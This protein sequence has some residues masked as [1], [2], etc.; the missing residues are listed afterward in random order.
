MF[1][2]KS[3]ISKTPRTTSSNPKHQPERKPEHQPI[4]VDFTRAGLKQFL[5]LNNRLGS[6]FIRGPILFHELKCYL[7]AYEVYSA[8]SA[9]EMMGAIDDVATATAHV[10][11]VTLDESCQ[12]VRYDDS[13]V[14][15]LRKVQGVWYITDIYSTDKAVGY[16]PVFFWKLIKRGARMILAHVLSGW[17][18]LTK[19]AKSDHGMKSDPATEE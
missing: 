13:I 3:C 15:M 17:K 8:M 14:L 19:S 11:N 12:M 9:I 7:S 10:P 5:A 1:I 4:K 2:Q 6:R 16:Q 18:R